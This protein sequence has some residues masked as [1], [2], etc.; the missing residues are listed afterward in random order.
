MPL[1]FQSIQSSQQI[2]IF[3]KVR[4]ANEFAKWRKTSFYVKFWMGRG[5][6]AQTFTQL[7]LV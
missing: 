2:P 6:F 4:L 7:V 3:A 5:K 1:T